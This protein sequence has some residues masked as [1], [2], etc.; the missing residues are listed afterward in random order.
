MYSEMSR[1]TFWKRGVPGWHLTLQNCSDIWQEMNEAIMFCIVG[2]I[3]WQPLERFTFCYLYQS[4]K[5]GWCWEP[6]FQNWST[7]TYII[8]PQY[9]HYPLEEVAEGNVLI[10]GSS[11]WGGMKG[12][13][14]HQLGWDWASG[15]HI[16]RGIAIQ[17]LGAMMT[18]P[19]SPRVV[20]EHWHCSRRMRQRVLSSNLSL[21]R[22]N[23]VIAHRSMCRLIFNGC[24]GVAVALPSSMHINEKHWYRSWKE[25]RS[26][27]PAT[28][29]AGTG[30]CD[31]VYH[32]VLPSDPCWLLTVMT[33]PSSLPVMEEHWH[34]SRRM[35][36]RVLPS[37]LSL[38][39]LNYVTAHRSMCHL[40]LN[41]CDSMAVAL[42][43]SMHII[44]EHWYR[45]WKE[46]RSASPATNLAGTGLCDCVY[47]G[48]SP[49]NPCWSW[50]QFHHHCI[51]S[52][53]ID[54]AR[55]G[56]GKGICWAISACCGWTLWQHIGAC[57]VQSLTDVMVW[58]LHCRH[59]HTLL[60]SID[61]LLEGETRSVTHT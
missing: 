38:L 6:L 36:Q 58:Q 51:S 20:K 17:S 50:W 4:S 24:D 8:N 14:S 29:L 46:R 1:P 48:V 25:R 23:F 2:R 43:S 12:Q 53:S 19:L 28:N 26:A 37:N 45:S 30:L 9:K 21:L 16:P 60:R 49:S 39:Q 31:C 44:E 3:S 11:W 35:R 42:P 33:V 5:N 54:I 47:H 40:I 59:R 34:R 10:M 41:G 56:W 32:G 7:W 15:L 61:W 52:R 57:V 55:G 13:S 22:L 27:S 18:V